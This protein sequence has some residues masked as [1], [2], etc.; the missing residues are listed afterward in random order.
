M[1]VRN[2]PCFIIIT[3]LMYTSYNLL[4]RMAQDRN[5]F[6]LPAGVPQQAWTVF[7]KWYSTSGAERTN[8]PI[9][10]GTFQNYRDWWDDWYGSEEEDSDSEEEEGDVEG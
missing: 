3:I 4:S 9:R 1:S 5:R 2:R 6:H 7:G 8:D 10:Q